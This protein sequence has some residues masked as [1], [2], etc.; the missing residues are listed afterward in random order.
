MTALVVVTK[1]ETRPAPAASLLRA[2]FDL[3]PAESR[4]CE[5]LLSGI[6]KTEL[7]EKFAI[8]GETERSHVRSILRKTGM[9][10]RVDLVRFLGGLSAPD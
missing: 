8:S 6:Q 7:Q 5:A 3:T 9:T 10:R 4:V 1:A 2:L